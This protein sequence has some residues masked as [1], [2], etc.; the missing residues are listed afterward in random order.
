M[1]AENLDFTT[2]KEKQKRKRHKLF[3]PRPNDF[4]AKEL[5]DLTLDDYRLIAINGVLHSHQISVE[6]DIEDNPRE[7]DRCRRRLEY[8][9]HVGYLDEHLKELVDRY[10][11]EAAVNIG[12]AEGDNGIASKIYG[13]GEVR[14]TRRRKGKIT[15]DVEDY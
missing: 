2:Q 1:N 10:G 3:T 13:R 6:R 12:W 8:G 4:P 15:H 5:D 11:T 7:Q 14:T 9:F